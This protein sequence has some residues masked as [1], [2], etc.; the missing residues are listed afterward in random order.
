MKHNVLT[1]VVVGLLF[2]L[3]VVSAAAAGRPH[4]PESGPEAAL[5]TTFTYQGQ[6]TDDGDPVTANCDMA[7]RLFDQAADGSQ[8][9]EA[10]S[11]TV[12]ISDG[13]FTV[14]LDFGSGPFDG[15]ALW[16]GIRVSCPGDADWTDLGRQELTAAPYALYA[17]GAPWT[18]IADRPPGLDDGD[19]NTTT[20]LGLALT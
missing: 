18:G 13:L 15:D 11:A 9:G 10:T 5:G 20:R 16:L 3:V 17:L 1:G 19:D 12:P 4:A 2:T 14:A 6:L 7:F 8:Q